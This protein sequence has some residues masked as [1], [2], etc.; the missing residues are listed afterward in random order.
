MICIVILLNACTKSGGS[1]PTPDP[2]TGITAKFSTDVLPIINASC[3]IN[4]SCHA[5]G[6]VNAGGPLTDYN[7][8]F[9]KRSEIKFQVEAGL[10]PKTGSI[11][12]TEKNKIICW[13][14]SGAPNN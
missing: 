13:I 12:A 4:S 11:T 2:C 1:S 9:A 6:S 7:K 14:N 3:A 10:M 5:A 8:I